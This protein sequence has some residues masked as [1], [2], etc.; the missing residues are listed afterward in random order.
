MTKLVSI[1]SIFLLFDS[2]KQTDK[3]AN[4]NLQFVYTIDKDGLY[5]YDLHNDS[6]KKIYSTDKVFLN[7]KVTFLNDTVLIV[8]HQNSIRHKKQERKVYTKYLYR[9][10]GDST[11]ITDNPPYI[12]I[13]EHDFV[14]EEYFAININNDQVYKCRTVDYEHIDHSTLKIHTKE[15]S[16][17]GQLLQETDTSFLCGATSYTSKGIKFCNDEGRFYSLSETVNNKQ[18]ISREGNLIQKV[19]NV[20][21]LILKFDGQF[22]PKFGSGYFAPTLS[23]NGNKV[24]YEYMAGF[25]KGGSAI[26]EMNLETNS[27]TELLGE[28]FF[29]PKYSPN[30]Q[31]LLVAKNQHQAPNNTWLSDI[32][33]LDIN[34]KKIK[35]IVQAESYWWIPKK[36]G[37]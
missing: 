31:K 8:G 10:D 28:G 22:E 11:F 30:G 35:Q 7:D 27:K 32:Y 29:E 15:F 24:T 4:N 23:P 17:N 2:C 13:D 14:T 19:G 18:I 26:Y 37:S 25:L 12:T 34:S 1:I 5:Y 21:T 36:Y 16:I 3:D 9:A 33:I 20:E 6:T